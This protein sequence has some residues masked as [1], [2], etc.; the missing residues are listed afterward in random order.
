[1]RVLLCGD[2]RVLKH[3]AENLDGELYYM[4]DGLI[5]NIR[6]IPET[7]TRDTYVQILKDYKFDFVVI[8]MMDDVKNA[9]YTLVTKENA[10]TA[11]IT[12]LVMKMS[13]VHKMYAAGANRVIPVE[14]VVSSALVNYAT[15]PNLARFIHNITFTDNVH[16]IGIEIGEAYVANGETAS[17][18]RIRDYTNSVIIGV[19]RNGFMIPMSA[20]LRF[21]KG[22][23]LIAMVP[24][25]EDVK[26]KTV[27]ERGSL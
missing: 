3:T 19:K 10:H 6:S 5:E 22:D 14:Y 27:L 26:L 20:E 16:I 18:L 8:A 13:S 25:G 2:S 7:L 17:K 15:K 1:M 11:H 24:E 9:F 21:R 12:V 4:G 23:I